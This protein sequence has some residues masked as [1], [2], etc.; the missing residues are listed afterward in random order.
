MRHKKR[1]IKLNRTSSH[2]RCLFA[3]MLKSLIDGEKIVTT[4]PKANVLRRFADR[5][6]TLAKKNTLASRRQVKQSLMLRY[7]TLTPKEKRRVKDGDTSSYN[8]DR[9]ILG[10]LFD[11]LG[12]RFQSREGGYTR[13]TKGG[14][15]I[16]DN[17]KRCIIEYLSE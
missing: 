14:T 16:G 10:K 3:N 5:M 2:R 8:V 9:R 7:N 13:I 17:A 4:F 6:I 15:R 11:E 1:T 12:P